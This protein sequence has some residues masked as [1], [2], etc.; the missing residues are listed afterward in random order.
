MTALPLVGA[1]IGATVFALVVLLRPPAVDPLVALARIDAAHRQPQHTH[2]HP[3]AQGGIEA[4]VGGWLADQLRRRG[5]RYTTL[6]Q[7]LT[8]T[9][10]SFDA[11]MGRKA[12]LATF[13]FLQIGRASCRE[14]V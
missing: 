3:T 1:A 4:T 11:T 5:V 9:G 6:R 14:R 7:D 10:Q 12:A 8:L 13:G 2:E